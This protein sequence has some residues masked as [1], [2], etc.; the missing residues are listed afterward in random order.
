MWAWATLQ[1]MWWLKVRRCADPFLFSA[2]LFPL[3][4]VNSWKP[5]EATDVRGGRLLWLRSPFSSPFG[6]VLSCPLSVS[7][8]FPFLD[9]GVCLWR[10]R[11]VWSLTR[12][13]NQEWCFPRHVPAWKWGLN[14]HAT[15]K[16]EFNQSAHNTAA[17]TV[18]LSYWE[19]VVKAFL[20]NIACFCSNWKLLSMTLVLKQAL[21]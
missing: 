18:I 17:R 20:A 4:P 1:C 3:H 5:A 16:Q 9:H 15:A 14:T 8:D 2:S 11:R 21:K 10:G 12:K 19:N 6:P 13:T 7:A